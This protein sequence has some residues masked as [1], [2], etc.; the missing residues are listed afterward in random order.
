MKLNRT[1]VLCLSI[2]LAASMALGGTL[3]FLTDTESKVNEFT[4]GNVDIDL[5]EN[6]P[7]NKLTPGV[8]LQKEVT[9]QN[10]GDND[11]YVWFTYALPVIANDDT[12]ASK[13]VLHTNTKGAY[14][15]D[16]RENSAYW[17][18]GQA[19][20]MPIEKTWDVDF[21]PDGTG[22]PVAYVDVPTALDAEGNPTDYIEYAVYANLYHGVLKAPGEGVAEADTVTTPGMSQVY[23]DTKLDFVDGKYC[24]VENGVATP[25]VGRDG[26][27]DENP[28]GIDQL[29]VIVN[30]YAIQY[31][32][33]EEATVAGAYNNYLGQ[34]GEESLKRN[35]VNAAIE[36]LKQNANENN[37]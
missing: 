37:P 9:I 24:I 19:A 3:A 4:V 34:W 18:E 11:A 30:A 1:L 15:D 27:G 33:L 36:A 21:H 16:Y 26:N 13:N 17:V 20:A 25:L 28:I 23:L 29:K 10:V 2:V 35:V 31:D 8:K 12:D 5:K 14:W 32:G 22:M 7:V 6:F